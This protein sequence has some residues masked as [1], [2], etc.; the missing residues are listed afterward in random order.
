MIGKDRAR[1]TSKYQTRAETRPSLVSVAVAGA[2]TV[3]QR[4]AK[5]QLLQLSMESF[6]MV[7]STSGRKTPP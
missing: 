1:L 5:A 3:K 2:M 7:Q 4:A 6:A